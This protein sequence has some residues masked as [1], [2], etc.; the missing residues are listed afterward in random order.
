MPT[1][2]TTDRLVQAAREYAVDKHG[3]QKRKSDGA[4]YLIHLEGVAGL[5]VEYGYKDSDLIAAALLHDTVEDTDATI[6]QLTEL[7][8]ESVAQLVYWLTDAERGSRKSRNMQTAWR[9]SRAPFEAKLIKLA[10]II[11]NGSAMRAHDVDIASVW[12]DEKR[13]IL[14]MMAEVEKN[15][16]MLLPLFQRAVTIT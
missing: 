13:Q 8:G 7:F 9:L 1:A 4:A 15:R 16:L 3:N 11:D 12:L 10:D 6:E 2:L 14:R 5:L